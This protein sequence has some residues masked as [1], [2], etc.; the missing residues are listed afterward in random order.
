[1]RNTVT[2]KLL[3]LKRRQELLRKQLSRKVRKWE[4]HPSQC[5][6]RKIRKLKSL[7][8]ELGVSQDPWKERFI[9]LSK[10]VIVSKVMDS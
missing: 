8:E 2:D 6:H 7:M 9:E 10:L 3:P 4:R 1:M 5:S